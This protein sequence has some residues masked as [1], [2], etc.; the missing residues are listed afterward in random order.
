MNFLI[1]ITELIITWFYLIAFPILKG[2][3]HVRYS[4][5][6]RH[7]R[8]AARDQ[9]KLRLHAWAFYGGDGNGDKSHTREEGMIHLILS[10]SLHF[11]HEYWVSIIKDW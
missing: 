9:I 2:C 6:L 8:A 11:T 7:F 5:P 1:N 10:L 4:N 3:F